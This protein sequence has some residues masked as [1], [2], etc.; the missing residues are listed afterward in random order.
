M[1]PFAYARATDTADAVRLFE[2]LPHARFLAGG[3]NLVDLMREQIEFPEALVD[4]TGLPLDQIE[5]RP[6]GSLLIGAVVTNTALAQHLGVRERFPMLAQAILFGASGQIR[7]MATVGGNLLQR[8]RCPYFYD[9]AAACNKR[10]P[11]AGCDAILGFNRNHAILGV[12]ESCVATHPSDMCV[13]L[14]A[15]DASV[16]ITGSQGDRVIPFAEFYLLP[17]DRPDLETTLHPGELI[18]AIEVPPLPFARHSRYRKVRDRA[19]YAFALVSVAA[20]LEV[21]DGVVTQVRLALG[22]VAPRPWRALD[23]EHVLRGAPATREVF[24]QAAEAELAS[25]RGLHHNAFKIELAKRTIT[26]VLAEMSEQGGR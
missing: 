11:G 23:A 4:I 6:D 17:G 1:R 26:S 18:T 2:D 25:A 24:Q 20:A 13:A 5:E 9:L 3:T 16:H 22:G 7:N 12:A 21:E 8:T 15:L 14:A 19:S 10:Q